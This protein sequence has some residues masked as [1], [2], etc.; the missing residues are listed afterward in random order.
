MYYISILIFLEKI[1]CNK[2]KDF[3]KSAFKYYKSKLV[4]LVTIIQAHS[5]QEFYSFANFFAILPRRLLFICG[6]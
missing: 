3:N 4:S 1:K 6:F 5:F 2:N